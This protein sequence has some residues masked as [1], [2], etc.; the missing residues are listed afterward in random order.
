MPGLLHDEDSPCSFC[1]QQYFPEEAALWITQ[2]S[3]REHDDR[4]EYVPITGGYAHFTCLCDE[5]N[6]PLWDITSE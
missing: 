4:A 1:G 2:G 5:W 6:L 3:L